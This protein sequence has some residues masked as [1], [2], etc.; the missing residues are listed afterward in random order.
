MIIKPLNREAINQIFLHL[1]DRGKEE[2]RIW[3][4]SEEERKA[5]LKK[6]LCMPW[7]LSFYLDDNGPACAFCCLD[8]V[9]TR[10]WRTHFMATDDGFNSIWF[11]LTR[12]FK[13][14]S[15]NLADGGATIECLTN[16]YNGQ[17]REWFEAMGF[18]LVASS[19]N[20]D[21]YVKFGTIYQAIGHGA[22]ES[23]CVLCVDQAQIK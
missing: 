17:A 11:P 13:K 8:A 18:S 2:C 22:K 20:V 1:W 16:P 4:I 15:D 9:D 14:L 6:L 23:E 7:R 10:R 12:Y 5:Y 19:G 3:G 21:K